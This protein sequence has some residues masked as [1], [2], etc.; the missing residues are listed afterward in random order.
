MANNGQVLREIPSVNKILT[1]L[2][3]N[4]ELALI[5]HERKREV[6]R[7]AIADLQRKIK[8]GGE[9]V[10]NESRL[11]AVI[12]EKLLAGSQPNL[13]PVV[14]ATGVILHTNLGRAPL[15][16]R[17]AAAVKAILEN[18]S[19]LEYDLATGERGSRYEL[20]V[21][22]IRQLTGAADA[23][24]VNNNAAAVLLAVT[25][26]AY[27]REVIVSRGQLVE[28]GGSFRIPEVISQS[29]AKL[30]EVGT[31]NKTH[32]EDYERAITDQ[33]AAILK[34]HPSNYRITGFTAQPDDRE[35]AALAR[36][37]GLPLIEDMGSGTLIPVR[38]PG[39]DET[40]VAERLRA[41]MDLVTFSGDKL[42]GGSQAGIIAGHKEYLGRMKKHPLLRAVRIDKLSLAAL[43]GT[44]NDYLWG[45]ARQDVPA[46]KMIGISPAVLLKRATTLAGLLTAIGGLTVAVQEVESLVGGGALPAVKLSGY[47]VVATPAVISGETLERRLRQNPIPICVRVKGAG[48]IFDVRCLTDRDLLLIRDACAGIMKEVRK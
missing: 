27:G 19:T 36:K 34:V 21:K 9:P 30:V 46:L 13:K 10:I 47:G 23:L 8:T 41:G 31:T 1:A 14:N 29:G 17:A 3:S 18:Y 38:V 37:F 6:V 44:L 35:L 24:V 22:Q 32:R 33:T 28:I 15:S 7:E 2:A 48:V 26:L 42:L 11:L 16:R 20:V 43:E 45:E 39:W 5:P 4:R 40:T 25:A 12:T